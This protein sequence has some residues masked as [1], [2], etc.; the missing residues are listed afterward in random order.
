MVEIDDVN[1]HGG[2]LLQSSQNKGIG[3]EEKRP[4]TRD[5]RRGSFKAAV[6]KIHSGQ[7]AWRGVETDTVPTDTVPDSHH[8]SGIPSGSEGDIARTGF[9]TWCADNK[10]HNVIVT[11]KY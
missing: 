4:D 5:C 9:R 11:L 10:E 1:I 8:S 2:C 6:K 7:S 3:R